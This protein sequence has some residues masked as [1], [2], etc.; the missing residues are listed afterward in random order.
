MANQIKNFEVQIN[1]AIFRTLILLFLILNANYGN[2]LIL[3]N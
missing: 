3:N 1:A 2:V